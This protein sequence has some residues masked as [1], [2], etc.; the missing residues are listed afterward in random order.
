MRQMR[1][2]LSKLKENRR[3]DS[4]RTCRVLL[5]FS[6]LVMVL[7]FMVLL[8]FLPRDLQWIISAAHESQFI[9]G[10]SIQF[11]IIINAAG[12]DEERLRRICDIL[13]SDL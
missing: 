8:V 9:I 1:V 5:L 13:A 2:S 3:E 11:T 12:N 6:F 10:Q 7:L 4:V